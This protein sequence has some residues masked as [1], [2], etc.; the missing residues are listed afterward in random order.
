MFKNEKL[1]DSKFNKYINKL[2]QNNIIKKTKRFLKYKLS[3]SL[4]LVNKI[5]KI[6][7]KIN[8]KDKNNIIENKKDKLEIK[9][10][11]L[12]KNEKKFKYLK[13]IKDIIL[14]KY[15]IGITEIIH[16]NIP[17]KNLFL[18]KLVS[19]IYEKI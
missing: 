4:K 17:I 15:K 6:K 7:E 1:F 11:A 16:Q 12:Y 5:E 19:S 2:I 9:S 3:F 8:I 14:S 13:S 18:F 10:F